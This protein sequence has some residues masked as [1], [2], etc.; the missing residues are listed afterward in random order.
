MKSDVN[1]VLISFMQSLVSVRTSLVNFFEE[2][3]LLSFYADNFSLSDFEVSI[4]LLECT[5]A[6]FAFHYLKKSYILHFY[7]TH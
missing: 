5:H 6:H 1:C 3:I 4:L 7:T 2:L